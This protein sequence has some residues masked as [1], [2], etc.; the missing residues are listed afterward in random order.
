MSTILS[1]QWRKIQQ[2]FTIIELM[3]TIAILGIMTAISM[4]SLNEFL[5]G[6][7]VDNEINQLQRMVLT[8][9]NAAVNLGQN[10]TLCPLNQNNNCTNNWSGELTVFVDLNQ[11][12]IFNPNDVAAVAAAPGVP[13]VSA[14]TAEI[15]IKIKK[16][17][18][19][20]D[21]LNYAAVTL[22]TFTPTGLLSNGLDGTFSYCP[23]GYTNLNRAIVISPSGR[24][25][26]STDA[27][28]DG[29]DEDR[30]NNAITCI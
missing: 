12:N 5:V 2:G 28:N 6:M 22:I 9:R 8:A 13:A 25:Y 20:V 19:A 11:D 18:K 29:E 10:V 14:V 17:I 7:R 21:T 1:V 27:D 3:I 26:Q 23:N 16:A 30:N 15:L 24:T 4:P